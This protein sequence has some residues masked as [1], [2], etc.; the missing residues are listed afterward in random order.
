L[1]ELRQLAAALQQQVAQ[2]QFVNQFGAQP[3]GD[4]KTQPKQEKK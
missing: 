1:Q 4:G 2:Q 3:L